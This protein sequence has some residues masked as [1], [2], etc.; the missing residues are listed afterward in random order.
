MMRLVLADMEPLAKVIGDCGSGTGNGTSFQ[1]L[2]HDA[3]TICDAASEA[4]SSCA[5]IHDELLVAEAWT[6]RSWPA[7]LPSRL[8]ERLSKL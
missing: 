5:S 4:A 3:E 8:F 1:R 7:F 2:D 6:D